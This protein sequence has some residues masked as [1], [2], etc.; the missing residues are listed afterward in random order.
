MWGKVT[1]SARF[2]ARYLNLRVGVTGKANILSFV[3]GIT[4]TTGNLASINVVSEMEANIAAVARK[5]F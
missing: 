1:N 4:L 3:V 5:G 2:T